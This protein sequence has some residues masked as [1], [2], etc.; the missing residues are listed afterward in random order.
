[1]KRSVPLFSVICVALLCVPSHAQN[2]GPN[3]NMVSGTQ[4]PGGDPFLQRQNEPS[5]GVSSRNPLH[6]MAGA[7]DY[8]TVDLPGLPVGVTADGWLG[9]F[10]SLDGGQTWKSTLLPGYPQDTSPE[11]TASGLKGYAAAA[12]PS[13][14][15]G[16]NGLFY[17]SGIAFNRGNNAL[18][19]LF[20]ARFI[21]NNDESA[22]PI[23][24]L[25]TKI[26]A[27]GT[28]SQ[29]IDKPCLAVDIPRGGATKITLNGKTFAVG[30]LYLTYSVIQGTDPNIQTT[31]YVTRSTDGGVTWSLPS[32][33]SQAI[34]IN[35]GTA[36]AIDPATGAVYVAWRRIK[37]LGAGGV[38]LE[39]DGLIVA[40]SVDMGRTFSFTN[41]VQIN[42]F[43]Q[44][45]TPVSFRTTMYP[46]I[47]VDGSGRIY[48]AWA[49][50]GVG[51]YGSARIL[52]V[53][54][55][56]ATTWTTP[57]VVAPSTNGGHQFLPSLSFAAGKLMVL[58]YDQQQD[59]TVGQ[60]APIAGSGGLYTETRTAA[61][62]L[63]ATP[64]QPTKVFN[65]YLAD[66]A[67]PSFVA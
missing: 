57:V 46:T 65:Q 37:R 28:T 51:P 7:N 27:S 41:A 10:K 12:D 36:I 52:M 18:G 59:G 4:W 1:M 38:V 67:P 60:Y 48:L 5:I 44:G 56:N 20:V 49:Q 35:Q 13:V 21:D 25:G 23:Q 53:T 6:L 15:A 29:F 22:D 32:K 62:D 54:S 24:Y 34:S 40:K 8:R 55:T 58:Y 19:N 39:P 2:P 14:R 31:I 50:A 47:A 61:G 64:P 45:T 66:A 63:A 3:I 33:I 16:A 42:P 9:L 43:E 11:G 26:V 30:N 17:Y